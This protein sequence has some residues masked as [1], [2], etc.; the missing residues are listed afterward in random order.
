MERYFGL[1]RGEVI[2][3]DKRQ[4]IREQIQHIFEDPKRFSD[5]VLATYDH[6]T[7][8][9]NF[10]C[11]VLPNGERKEH[12]L[13][14]WSHPIR[15]GLYAG[16]RIEQ[17]YDITEHKR[18]EE[19]LRLLQTMTLAIS[20]AE[21]L[22]PSLGVV[23]HKVCDATGWVF[24]EAWVPRPDG[25]CLGCSLAWY[26]SVEGLEKFRKTSA[27]LTLSPGVGLPGRVWFS[28]KPAW[29]RDVTRDTNF[30]RA[31]FAREV[32]LKAA[33]AIPVQS[34]H[35]VLAVMEF[36]AFEPREEDER[37]IRLISTVAAQLGSVI[38][39]KLA[40][41]ALQESEERFPGEARP[42]RSICRL[43]PESWKR[44]PNR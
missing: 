16:G 3:K 32:G 36:Y 6:N 37:L 4:L 20:E 19:Q 5:K 7:Y 31:S 13:E 2:E 12:W 38:R 8:V 30:P 40:E 24:G 41:E 17:Y 28:K 9:E 11:H 21:D 1:R 14:H 34:N 43:F 25:S 18:T 35:E 26:S 27:W 29:V 42:S 23:L 39:R 33:K 10:E 44:R 22:H 15:S